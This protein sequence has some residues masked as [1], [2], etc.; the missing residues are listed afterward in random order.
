[1]SWKRENSKLWRRCDGAEVRVCDAA[2]GDGGGLPWVAAAP[3]GRAL[4]RRAAPGRQGAPL[5]FGTAPAAMAAL[6]LACPLQAELPL[7]C[8]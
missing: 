8:L 6:D 1:M 2:R 3:G 5:R 7:P 4:A